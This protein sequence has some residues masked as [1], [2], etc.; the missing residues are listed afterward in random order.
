M[1]TDGR[2]SKG[3]AHADRRQGIVHTGVYKN[4]QGGLVR[5]R[6]LRAPSR[7][8]L[9]AVRTDAPT[10][11]HNT[12]YTGA[13]TS[14]PSVRADCTMPHHTARLC[15]CTIWLCDCTRLHHMAQ[16]APSRSLS[17]GAVPVQYGAVCGM[18]QPCRTAHT[19]FRFCAC[20]AHTRHRAHRRMFPRVRGAHTASCTWAHAAVRLPHAASR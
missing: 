11:T 1:H 4:E 18:V 13:D 16:T 15:D 5:A 20:A 9:G 14:S 8:H 12:V 7:H 10:G 3:R 17:L 2:A 6:H 19:S